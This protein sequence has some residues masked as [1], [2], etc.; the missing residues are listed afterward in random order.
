MCAEVNCDIKTGVLFRI[1][2]N[3]YLIPF[4]KTIKISKSITLTNLTPAH[5]GCCC[6]LFVCLFVG[7]FVGFICG[8]FFYTALR[9]LVVIYLHCWDLVAFSSILRVPWLLL[10]PRRG[11]EGRVQSGVSVWGRQEQLP[12]VY[13]Q[14]C[15]V[16]SGIA[17]YG[18][19]PC[20]DCQSLF[21][22]IDK[23]IVLHHALMQPLILGEA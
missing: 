17:S 15:S 18:H 12:P 1:K 21:M 2:L 3:V 22:Q 11:V 16:P 8:F 4:S 5:H 13:R 7:F 6:F 19:R 23:I 20:R 10:P 14:V 9:Y